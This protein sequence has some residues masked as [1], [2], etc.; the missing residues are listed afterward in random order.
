V[1]GSVTERQTLGDP[2]SVG[3]VHDHG[4]AETAEALGVFGLGKMAAARA[5]AHD[6]AGAGDFKPFGHGFLGFDAFWTS[7]KIISIAKE[8]GIYV[9][10]SAVA[11][12]KFFLTG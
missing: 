10:I 4:F 7:H 2:V 11:S 3:L 6:L 1:I 8:R 5:G 9:F 12:A